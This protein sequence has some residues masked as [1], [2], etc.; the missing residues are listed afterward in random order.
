[1]ARISGTPS[2]GRCLLRYGHSDAILRNEITRFVELI[3]GSPFLTPTKAEL[4]DVSCRR[5]A[6]RSAEP[7]RQASA[8][9]ATDEAISSRRHKRGAK[10]GGGIIGADDQFD[11]RQFNLNLISNQAQK[12]N[13]IAETLDT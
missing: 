13:L 8:A 12:R 10:I 5:A 9:I 4:R 2:T 7:G 1:M 6:L 11:R 3:F